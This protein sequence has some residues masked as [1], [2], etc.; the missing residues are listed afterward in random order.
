MGTDYPID[1]VP[2]SKRPRREDKPVSFLDQL[3]GMAGSFK[4]GKITLFTKVERKKTPELKLN[5][6]MRF[7]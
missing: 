1:A 4:K 5:Q 7:S 6:C 3:I 2:I